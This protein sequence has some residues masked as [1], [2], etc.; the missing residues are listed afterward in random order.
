MPQQSCSDASSSNVD[1]NIEGTSQG[2]RTRSGMR[3]EHLLI[4]V[5]LNNIEHIIVSISAMSLFSKPDK[6]IKLSNAEAVTKM[7]ALA[8]FHDELCKKYFCRHSNS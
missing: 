3:V 7:L 6:A 1:M 2:Y 4:K 8:K 5:S